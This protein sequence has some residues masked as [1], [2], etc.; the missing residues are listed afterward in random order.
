MW[1]P[2]PPSFFWKARRCSARSAKTQGGEARVLCRAAC[3]GSRPTRGREWQNT[4]MSLMGLDMGVSK[5]GVP[6]NGWFI[7]EIPMKLDDLGV[8]LFLETSIYFDRLE[9]VIIYANLSD[10]I[11]SLQFGKIIPID[12]WPIFLECQ[13]PTFEVVTMWFLVASSGWMAF[14]CA[15][16]P[17]CCQTN[18]NVEHVGIE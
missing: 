8:S 9:F 5:I 12:Y 10:D 6:Q 15:K 2:H 16:L 13:R 1:F 18:S 7:K 14:F 3:I 4:V 17:V 11:H